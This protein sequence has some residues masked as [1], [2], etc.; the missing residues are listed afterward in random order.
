MPQQV[1]P[2]RWAPPMRL[3]CIKTEKTPTLAHTFTGV[4]TSN[5]TET[6]LPFRTVIRDSYPHSN[7]DKVT[8]LENDGITHLQNAGFYLPDDTA[9]R[10][11]ES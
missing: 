5:P 1:S 4:K 7:V 11:Q 10:G 6:A 8:R 2:N 3:K 9:F